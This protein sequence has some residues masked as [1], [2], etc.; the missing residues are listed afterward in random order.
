MHRALV[1]PSHPRSHAPPLARTISFIQCPELES[2]PSSANPTP[3]SP[4]S[5]IASSAKSSASSA[6]S[7]SPRATASSASAPTDDVQM[8]LLDTPGLLNPRYALQRA[9]RGTALARARTMPTSIVYLADAHRARSRPARRGRA[10]STSPPTRARRH[11]AQQGRRAHARSSA[12]SS[13]ERYP[14]ARFISALTGE[15]VDELLAELASA[16]P[17]SPFL[18]PE[19]EIST[20]AGSL[21]R[22]GAR[23]RDGA[24]AARRGSALQPRVRGRGVSGRPDARVHSD[25][26]AR[27]ARKP[28]AHPHRRRWPA[29]PRRSGGP[30][31][32]RSKQFVG[33]RV[34]LDLWVKVLPNWRRRA[35][36][37]CSA[38]AIDFHEDPS[39]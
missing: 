24:R 32:R 6:R 19:D 5:S 39:A 25:G 36:A 29:D 16:L 23:A 18:Y 37:R 15:G 17:E 13:R 27:R 28:E 12:T 26:S 11:G 3:E 31:A 35:T 34:Y 10:S 7:R 2:S 33:A 8:I 1:S 21:L 14:D 9:M 4:R 20:A 22:R 30:R 38:S